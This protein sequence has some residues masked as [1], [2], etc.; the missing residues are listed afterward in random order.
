MERIGS[1]SRETWGRE[2]TRE[3][4]L[5]SPRNTSPAA[6]HALLLL[7]RRNTRRRRWRGSIVEDNDLVWARRRHEGPCVSWGSASD[8]RSRIGSRGVRLVRARTRPSRAAGAT[9]RTP[10]FGAARSRRGA[11]HATA[12]ARQGRETL[13]TCRR[14][15]PTHAPKATG[16]LA[17]RR[18]TMAAPVIRVRVHAGAPARARALLLYPNMPPSELERYDARSRA[19][20]IATRLGAC[21]QGAHHA[22]R[23]P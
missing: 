12:H 20:A 3:G 19:G 6:T 16:H 22:R 18:Q 17:R 21:R 5:E 2:E 23:R 11:T 14:A 9:Q 1:C 4:Q 13:I 8:A 10:H 15:G 7:E